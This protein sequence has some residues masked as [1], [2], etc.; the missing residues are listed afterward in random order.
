MTG[1]TNHAA[2]VR[3]ITL[4]ASLAAVVVS[5]AIPAIYFEVSR[6]SLNAAA[7]ADAEQLARATTR[8]IADHPTTW[9]TQKVQLLDL[10]G[11]PSL[12]Y[13][14]SA[15]IID[16]GGRTVIST[17]SGVPMPLL[18]QR[19]KVLLS[20][21]EVAEIDRRVSLRPLA[22]RTSLLLA[23]SALLGIA[24]FLVLKV[25]PLRALE[26]TIADLEEERLRVKRHGED[27]ELANAKLSAA[28]VQLG[29]ANQDAEAANAELA[30]ANL[31]LF[32]ANRETLAAVEAKSL[33]LATMSHE[34]RT[35]MNGVIGMTELLL[36]TPL[37]AEQREFADNIR[38]SGD[39]LLRVINDI[40]DFSKIESGHVE[41]D[42][43]LT[44]IPAVI[45]DVFNIMSA[46][47][48]E[49]NLEL[50]Y[51]VKPPV[52]AF[53]FADPA[54]LQQILLNLV[55]NAIKFTAQ[56]QVVITVT[57]RG[58][59]LS[60]K[61]A[62]QKDCI[63]FS[64]KDSGIGIP[65]D[66]QHRLFQPFSQVD[67]STS[68]RYGGT[69]LGLAICRRL[70]ELMGGSIGVNSGKILPSGQMEA[71]S[72]FVFDIRVKGAP[73]EPRGNLDQSRIDVRGKRVMVI[74]DNAA[75]R[76]VLAAYCSHWGLVATQFA[77]AAQA[78]DTLR[79][80]T[81][82]DA[83]I[84]DVQMPDIGGVEFAMRAKL[85]INSLNM[86]PLPM[87]LL[88]ASS[89]DEKIEMPELF[90]QTLGKPLK[91]ATLL[92]ALSNALT[93]TSSPP[94]IVT[95]T[96]R[97]IDSGLG[98]R[99][100][101]RILAAEDNAMN[102]LVATRIFERLGYEIDTVENGKLAVEACLA[103][104]Y[105]VVFMDVQM[106]VMDGLVATRLIRDQSKRIGKP[107][108]IALT[109]DAM[110]EDRDKCMRAG[111][112]DYLSKPISS[113]R[114]TEMLEKYGPSALR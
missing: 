74:D 29:S 30:E 96:Q 27:I 63:V 36:D 31:A 97:S 109:A 86:K 85:L 35:P 98:A 114:L 70:C 6:S 78:L 77:S 95:T 53:I 39:A 2:M 72:E 60:G 81:F 49:K 88:Q 23:V 58:D 12:D 26:R 4:I 14:Q 90:V 62:E 89:G 111:M 83:A 100:P 76:E 71:G 66:K 1:Q 16:S 17:L 103:K 22:E 9:S 59:A 5:F 18:T 19:V 107:I 102:Q 108:I 67:S 20:G 42:S 15:S 48:R 105:D 13:N 94:T 47:A 75:N 112:D 91:P 21:A 69:G 56:G 54:R 7:T 84:V 101:L 80:G 52:P 82:F 93:V 33:F 24:I 61:T 64:I 46:K 34:I 92:E 25:L 68:R 50:L 87:L 28:N 51:I 11:G 37:D 10:L 110:P 32:E 40:L 45:E 113:K 57:L 38:I 73:A 3:S 41:L 43:R 8:F 44:E 104:V 106:P 99:L 55:S 65:E 79:V